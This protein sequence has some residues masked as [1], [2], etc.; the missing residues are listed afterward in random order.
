MFLLYI[1]F[2]YFC[3]YFLLSRFISLS[4]FRSSVLSPFLSM[5]SSLSFFLHSI[6]LRFLFNFPYLLLRRCYKKRCKIHLVSSLNE[7]QRAWLHVTLLRIFPLLKRRLK[8]LN[9]FSFGQVPILSGQ[10]E[11]KPVRFD[12]GSRN[13]S[14]HL[15]LATRPTACLL[16]GT[17]PSSLVPAAPFRKHLMVQL[18]PKESL[19]LLSF[20]LTAAVV[21]F[22]EWDVSR[23]G[24]V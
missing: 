6:G 5:S 11:L 2:F 16:D 20:I 24:F 13:I 22:S 9:N 15:S 17:D 3:H 18:V 19:L 14:Y 10:S 1:F 21:S 12:S 4:L 23:I 8:S 7:Y